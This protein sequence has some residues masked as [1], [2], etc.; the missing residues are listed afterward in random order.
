MDT[1]PYRVLPTKQETIKKGYW[2]HRL[3]RLHEW[4]PVYDI[5]VIQQ[6]NPT[7]GEFLNLIDE[8]ECII[9]GKTVRTNQLLDERITNVFNY[10]IAG[11]YEYGKLKREG[12][13]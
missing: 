13:I 5:K 8:Y 7:P 11:L 1:T 6:I 2:F 10:Y 3:F 9:C 12:L 4:R